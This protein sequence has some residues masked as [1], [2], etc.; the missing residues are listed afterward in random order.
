M[1]D[2]PAY[3]VATDQSMAWG[4]QDRRIGLLLGCDPGSPKRATLILQRY[5]P[6]GRKL[7]PVDVSKVVKIAGRVLGCPS[8]LEVKRKTDDYG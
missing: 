3:V 5:E 4:I 2:R 1:A 6:D 7:N 8:D